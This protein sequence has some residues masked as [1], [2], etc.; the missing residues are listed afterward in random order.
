MCLRV[1]IRDH[2]HM[3]ISVCKSQRYHA[4][5][6]ST[7]SI[8]LSPTPNDASKA[9]QRKVYT[10][11][12]N[13]RARLAHSHARKWNRLKC[14]AQLLA[15]VRVKR[16]ESEWEEGRVNPLFLPTHPQNSHSIA[17]RNRENPYLRIRMCESCLCLR[18]WLLVPQTQLHIHTHT[19]TRYQQSHKLCSE[20]DSLF[21]FV[22][23]PSP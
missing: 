15:K 9:K 20:Y 4:L 13:P 17:V 5:S 1:H 21:S 18:A 8:H 3:Q 14:W 6:W 22:S 10:P 12:C 19:H 11:A 2:L 16:E 7:P 23:V